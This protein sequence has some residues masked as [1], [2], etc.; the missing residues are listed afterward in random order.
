M[1]TGVNG[2]ANEICASPATSRLPARAQP[3]ENVARATAVERAGARCMAMVDMV[4]SPQS[5]SNDARHL[6]GTRPIS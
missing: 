4:R 5:L 3:I 2:S 6:L 1:G